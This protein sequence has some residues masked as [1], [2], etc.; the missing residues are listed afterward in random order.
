MDLI[1]LSRD[2]FRPSYC[3]PWSTREIIACFKSAPTDG[4]TFLTRYHV[5]FWFTLCYHAILIALH[6]HLRGNRARFSQSRCFIALAS[7]HNLALSLASLY[8]FVDVSYE[9]YLTSMNSSISDT[10]CSRTLSP[11]HAHVLYIFLW[12]KIWEYFDTVLLIL[13]GRPVSILH[14]WH[15][16]SVAWEVRGWLVHGFS[17]G[18][19][20]MFFN[21]FIHIIMYAYYFTSLLRLPFPFKKAITLSQIVQFLCGFLSL[22]PFFHYDRIVEGGCGGKHALAFTAFCNFSYLVL[23]IRFYKQTYSKKSKRSKTP[24]RLKQQKQKKKSKSEK[25]N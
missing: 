18:L 25:L 19:W 20:G 4:T 2:N 23:F 24:K 8:M 5:L 14:I 11:R 22:I 17:L 12:T 1:S 7:L 9:I 13:R 6:F 16:T 10:V 21:S 3:V 15:H